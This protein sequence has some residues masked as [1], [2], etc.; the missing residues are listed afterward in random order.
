MASQTNNRRTSAL[1]LGL[2]YTVIVIAILVILNFVAN[3]YNKSYDSTATKQFTL[4]DQTIK[5]AKNLQQPLKITYWDQPTKFTAA[6]DL[7]D[8]YKNLSPKID[9]QYNDADKKYTQARAAG[10]KSLGTI[11]VDI[12]NKHQE[13]KSLTEEE[14][15]GAIVRALKGGERLACF[16]LGSGEH[17]IDSTE[18][19]GYSMA[20][21]LLEKNNYKTQT[22]K[23]L[24][25]TEIPKDC[26]IVTVAGPQRDYV[27]LE[28]D[29]LKAYVEGGGHA[30]FMVDP[31]LK[32]ARNEVDDNDALIGVL[33]G[34]G[35]TADK[36]LV[37]DTSGI[38]QA[39]GLGPEMPLVASY[40]SHAIVNT[41]KESP[42][43]FP[44]ARSLEVK[45]GDKTTDEKLFSTS[46]N[47]FATVNLA[48]SEIKQSPN[49][50]KGPLTL[51]AAGTYNGT[52]DAKGR[53]VVIG[54]SNWC[55]NS[56]LRFAGNRDLFLNIFNWLSSD[57]DLISIRPKEPEDRRLNMNASQVL[58][59]KYTALL[60]I[61][62]FILL[63]GVSVWWKRRAA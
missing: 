44:I 7:L 9:V 18:R 46:E 22:L 13:A 51:G 28:V 57:E 45:S 35:I 16:V 38:G 15:T 54:S 33:A 55:S 27:Q 1:S 30:L 49:D 8:R 32:F 14:V 60:L 5:I 42:T 11:F 20:K 37:L 2:L 52:A 24:E 29:A 25:K 59:V 12:G 58:M 61:P 62:L 3:R 40:E 41:M 56:F 36:D 23:M 6:R 34:W 21:D 47:S 17:S 19:S 26:T 53:F 50:K 31:P 39:M 4:S 48:T 43:L 10:V 63:A